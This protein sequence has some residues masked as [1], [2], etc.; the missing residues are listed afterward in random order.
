MTKKGEITVFCTCLVLTVLKP[1]GNPGNKTFS[2]YIS[3]I[4]S[5]FSII[6]LTNTG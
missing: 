3:I 4:S 1:C 2:S 5:H 6:Q